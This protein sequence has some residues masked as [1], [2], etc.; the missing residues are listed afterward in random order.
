MD[1]QTHGI[2]MMAD[3]LLDNNH[4][5]AA[6]RKVSVVR[7]RINRARAAGHRF[8]TCIP[9]VCEL[10]VGIQQTAAPADYYRRWSRLLEKVR[11]WPTD[12]AT[13]KIYGA[14][15]HKLRRAGRVMSQVDL[16][17]AAM[18]LQRSLTLLTTDRDFEAFPDVK[19]ENWVA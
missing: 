16:M 19:T 15:Y 8:G 4:L 9:A 5:G 17:L 13:A 6:I 10:E 12:L 11:L 2:G 18:A 7:D 3:Y 1:A 14:L